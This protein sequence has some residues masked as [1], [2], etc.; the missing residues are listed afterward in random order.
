[1]ASPDMMGKEF[2]EEQIIKEELEGIKNPFEEKLDHEEDKTAFE[3]ALVN[4][5]N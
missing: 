1:M 2:E 4:T 3:I 5:R